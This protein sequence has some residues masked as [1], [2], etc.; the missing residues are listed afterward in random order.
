[1]TTKSR[2]LIDNAIYHIVVR[3]N[4]KEPVFNSEEDYKKYLKVLWKYK[5][6]YKA[7]I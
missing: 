1:M 4:R 7:K 2:V 3:G 6:K 5:N